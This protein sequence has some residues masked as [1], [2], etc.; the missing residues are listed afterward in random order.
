MTM[1][2]ILPSPLFR[3][4][5]A[6]LLLVAAVCLS[7]DRAAAA[8]GDH[9]IILNAPGN[10]DRHAA[11]DA[12]ELPAPPCHGPNCSG[13]PERDVPPLAPVTS[14][15]LQ[16]KEMVQ[17]LGLTGGGDTPRCSFERDC[18]STRPIQRPNSIFH[19]PRVG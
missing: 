12:S 8:C 11:P 10:S 7:P 1:R 17:S 4:W 2:A 3:G 19:P 5:R 16:V 15:N 18:T 14:I 9:V 13:T 6:A